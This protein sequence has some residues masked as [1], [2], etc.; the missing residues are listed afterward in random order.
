MALLDF[1][2]PIGKIADKLIPDPQAKRQFQLEMAK[3]AQQADEREHQEAM[4]QLE[5][6]KVE[7]S[8]ASVFV[9]GWRP[10]IGWVLGTGAAIGFVCIP[11]YKMFTVAGYEYPIEHLITLL[12][13]LLGWSGIRSFD[14]LKGIAFTKLGDD[15][16][17]TQV[18][19]V[20]GS[21][22]PA[23]A[24]KLPIHTEDGQPRGDQTA[25]VAERASVPFAVSPRQICWG[26]KVSKTFK[27]RVLWIEQK[28]G[29][30]ADYLMACMAFETGLTFSASVRNAAGSSGTGLIQFME[31][32]A[33]KLG[34]TTKALAKMSA[35]DQLNYVYKYFRQ[36]G[37]DL[38]RWSLED[39]YMAILYPKAI[40]QPLS[41]KFPWAQTSLSYKQNRGLDKN[42]DGMVT[43]AEASAGVQKMLKEGMERM[44]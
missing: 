38:S 19:R 5:V 7:A 12:G 32:T 42:K 44:G 25:E 18:K 20:E 2:G 24:Q 17:M 35:E 33:S 43:K 30:N 26:S 15:P 21:A 27:A 11:L 16:G 3:L 13:G 4:G 31:F 9:A 41:W 14:K 40:G 6:N 36:F 37:T 22:T 34:T 39:V 1:L 23:I 29:L 10:Y 8:H 28:L